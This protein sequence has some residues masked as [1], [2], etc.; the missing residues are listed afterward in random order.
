MGFLRVEPPLTPHPA[1]I[2]C[3]VLGTHEEKRLCLGG[4]GCASPPFT[5]P[6]S[7]QFHDQ[8]QPSPDLG[9]MEGLL[10]LS[11][12]SGGL[13]ALFVWMCPIGLNKYLI[14]HLILGPFPEL[15]SL[16]RPGHVP[17]PLL[18]GLLRSTTMTLTSQ[19]PAAS[20]CI[21]DK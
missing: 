3:R 11:L 16:L 21:L 7:T 4:R 5:Q 12:P 13:P 17:H 14:S 2:T 15:S 6:V 1:V 20:S 10:V 18:W 19:T 9:A 8:S